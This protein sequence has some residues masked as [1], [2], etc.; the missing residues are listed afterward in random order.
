MFVMSI[1]LCFS[2][3]QNTETS[4]DENYT[5]SDEYL[6][7]DKNQ[8][9]YA[10]DNSLEHMPDVTD[11]NPLQHNSFSK[12]PETVM[13]VF[14]GDRRLWFVLESGL[15]YDADVE[16]MFISENK[17]I[18]KMY[19]NLIGNEGSKKWAEENV[20]IDTFPNP[21]SRERFV[22][23]DFDGKTD[24]EIID[25]ISSNYADASVQYDLVCSNSY[26]SNISMT[27]HGCSYPFEIQY[28]G[29]LDQSGNYLSSEKI[30][31]SHCKKIDNNTMQSIKAD[32]TYMGI[33][34]PTTI[35]NKQ[36]VGFK[37]SNIV[38]ENTFADWGELTLDDPSGVC[39][40]K[41]WDL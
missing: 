37:Y 18:L 23:S 7:S 36:Y 38:T 16:V 29:H 30:R 31:I 14:D 19:Y 40:W 9:D 11:K 13:D 4:S 24:D 20:V 32:F 2:G 22:L 21:Y 34:E 35:K 33:Y 8:N 3:C 15:S 27:H 39:E 6:E 10:E 5:Y 26:R 12:A 25:L 17:K 41:E 28:C 1:I